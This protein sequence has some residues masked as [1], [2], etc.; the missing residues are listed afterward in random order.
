VFTGAG[1]DVVHAADGYRDRIHCGSGRDV[2]WADAGFEEDRV[3]ADCEVVYR[4][5]RVQLGT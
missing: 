5:R 1:N 4:F 3:D 2:V